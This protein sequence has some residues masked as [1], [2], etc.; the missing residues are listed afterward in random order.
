MLPYASCAVT[1]TVAAVPAVAV[2]GALTTRTEVAAGET[3]IAPEVPV[4]EPSEAET[5]REPAVLR[6][7]G[8]A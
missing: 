3:A 2:A 8:K 4:L 7:T 1:V 6:V 5:V